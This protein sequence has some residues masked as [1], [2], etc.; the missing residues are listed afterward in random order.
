VTSLCGERDPF[1][2]SAGCLEAAGHVGQHHTSLRD[3]V[4]FHW[5]WVEPRPSLF[6]VGR[7]V[8]TKNVGRARVLIRAETRRLRAPLVD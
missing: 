7:D 1:D 5:G 2:P 8:L 3:G 6:L 4:R